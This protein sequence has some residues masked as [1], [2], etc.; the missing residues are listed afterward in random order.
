[1]VNLRDFLERREKE[2]TERHAQQRRQVIPIDAELAEVERALKAI[3]P[4]NEPILTGRS[5]T[6]LRL[7]LQKRE[8][9]LREMLATIYQSQEDIEYEL[10][11]IRSVKTAV[12]SKDSAIVWPNAVEV[13]YGSM[14]LRE[15]IIKALKEHF[16]TGA[17]IG[18]LLEFFR[19]KWGREIDRQSLSPQLSRL[20]SASQ[21]TQFGDGREWHLLP[22]RP[23]GHGDYHPYRNTTSGEV[24]WML[25]NHARE[26]DVPGKIRESSRPDFEC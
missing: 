15:L 20:F 17:T 7:Y 11:E 23:E 24:R 6:G 5:P 14:T 12:G 8:V 10:D 4:E 21:I 26:D 2:L 18:Q 22:P 1:M 25:R 9:E 19:D 13:P 3:I 16:P